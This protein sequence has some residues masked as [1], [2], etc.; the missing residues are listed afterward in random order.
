MAYCDYLNEDIIATCGKNGVGLRNVGY[1]FNR[2]DVEHIDQNNIVLG[3]NA[4]GY[5]FEQGGRH[6]FVGT[7]S[8]LVS[9]SL[10]SYYRHVVKAI[11][12]DKRIIEKMR[13]GRFIVILDRGE[14]GDEHSNTSFECFGVHSGMTLEEANVDYWNEDTDA[15][16][17]V[18]LIENN[19]TMAVNAYTNVSYKEAKEALDKC[20]TTICMDAEVIDGTLYLEDAEVINNTLIIKQHGRK[21]S[22]SQDWRNIRNRNF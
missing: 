6:P 5:L 16:W 22:N 10:R 9:G 18:S 4:T 1:I 15:G 7:T 19:G 17:E 20:T 2:E 14:S 11:I 3:I 13:N 8:E 12:F 21:N